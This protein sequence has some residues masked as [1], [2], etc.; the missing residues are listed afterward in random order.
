MASMA[1][2]VRNRVFGAGLLVAAGLVAGCSG[3]DG[4]ELNGKIFDAIGL[5]G[6]PFAKKIEPR[7][8]ARA[9][10]VLPPDANKLPEPGAT[11]MPAPVAA[12]G[13]PQGPGA[14]IVTGSVDPAWP[15]DRDALRATDA[16]SKKRAQEQHCK[17]GNWKQKAHKEEIAADSGPAGSCSGSIFSVLGNSLFGSD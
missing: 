17:D 7:T 3:G 15:K 14:Q 5:S 9:P 13:A 12:V 8:Q 6:D 1:K 16:D 11:A 4:I 10:L 2:R